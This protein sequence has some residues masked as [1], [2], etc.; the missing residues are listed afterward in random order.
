MPVLEPQQTVPC[1]YFTMISPFTNPYLISNGF[2]YLPINRSGLLFAVLQNESLSDKANICQQTCKQ[3][4]V[5]ALCAKLYVFLPHFPAILRLYSL[6]HHVE[7]I[8]LSTKGNVM[9]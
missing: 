7:T 2:I 1:T 4:Y 9:S 8:Y 6:N 3:F 5:I